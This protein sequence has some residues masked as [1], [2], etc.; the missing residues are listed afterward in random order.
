MSPITFYLLLTIT[1][2]LKIPS[3][4]FNVLSVYYVDFSNHIPFSH[5]MFFFNIN[6]TTNNNLLLQNKY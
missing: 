3:I 1:N 6:N 4:Y 2:L 5:K